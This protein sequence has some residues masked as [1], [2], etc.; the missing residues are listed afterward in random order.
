MRDRLL[1]GH[2]RVV[3]RRNRERHPARRGGAVTRAGEAAQEEGNVLVP[4]RCPDAPV[5]SADRAREN[6]EYVRRLLRRKQPEFAARLEA[7]E[8]ELSCSWQADGDDAWPASFS[9]G[10]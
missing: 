3:H 8:R 4:I 10:A 9:A 7:A 5:T 6:R 2:E 1:C